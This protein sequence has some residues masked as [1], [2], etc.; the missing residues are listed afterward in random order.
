MPGSGNEQIG[1]TTTIIDDKEPGFLTQEGN[2]KESG[3]EEERKREHMHECEQDVSCAVHLDNRF[4][5]RAR[6]PTASSE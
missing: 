5:T 4:C 3:R 1:A 6:H 2:V